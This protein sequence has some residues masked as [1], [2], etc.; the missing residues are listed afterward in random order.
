MEPIPVGGPICGKFVKS[1][2][3]QKVDD[4]NNFQVV[5]K[6]VYVDAPVPPPIVKFVKNYIEPPPRTVQVE[7]IVEKT[8][9]PKVVIVKTEIEKEP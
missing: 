2:I 1:R 3:D 5:E 7:K 8:P 9:K 4:K 6:I